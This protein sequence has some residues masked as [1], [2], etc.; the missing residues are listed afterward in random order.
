MNGYSICTQ[1]KNEGH[2]FIG[3]ENVCASSG[4]NQNVL[5]KINIP[6]TEKINAL[7]YLYDFDINSFSLM[8]TEDSLSKT[9]AFKGLELKGNL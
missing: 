6:R 9:L 3:H 2:E 7:S 4:K 5:I 1:K 8:Q